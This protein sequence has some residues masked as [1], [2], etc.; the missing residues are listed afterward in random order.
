MRKLVRTLGFTG[1]TALGMIASSAQAGVM[2][3]QD[4]FDTDLGTSSLNFTSFN[5]W[6]V[7]NGTVDYIRSP[8]SWD[9]NCAVGCVDIDGST[10]NGGRITSNPVFNI[11]AEHTYRLSADISG[12]QRTASIENLNFGFSDFFATEVINPGN[13]FTSYSTIIT[14]LSFVGSIFFE[15]TSNDNIGA[16]IDNVALECVTCEI[17]TVPEPGVIE[18]L[19]L[20]LASVGFA[21]KRKTASA[22]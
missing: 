13:V 11:L 2:L 18:L 4:N 15:T 6:T 3:F 22:I 19:A 1:L 7:D 20:G 8:N 17:P 12:N 14:G 16:I 9:I 10:G 5:N 21:R